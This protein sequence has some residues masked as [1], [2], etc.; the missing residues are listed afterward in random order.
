[1]ENRLIFLYRLLLR[2]GDGEGYTG[3]VLDVPV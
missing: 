1:M 3:R 2:W